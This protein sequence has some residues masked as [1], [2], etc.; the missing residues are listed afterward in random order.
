MS[1]AREE[2]LSRLSATTAV[3]IPAAEYAQL[4]AAPKPREFLFALQTD[5]DGV[6]RGQFDA[7][8]PGGCCFPLKRNVNILVYPIE[9]E[10]K[11]S[12]HVKGEANV[13]MEWNYIV[14]MRIRT[15]SRKNRIM[16]VV[17][18]D[19]FEFGG[20]EDPVI[21]D[22]NDPQVEK[23]RFDIRFIRQMVDV[24]PTFEFGNIELDFNDGFPNL[25]VHK[26]LLALHSSY[27]AHT[28]E[29]VENGSAINMG[30]TPRHCFQEVLYQIHRIQRPV[31]VDFRAL[32]LGALT[33]QV[34]TVLESLVRH[35]INYE[36]LSLEQKL[37]EAARLQLLDAIGELA[38]KAEQ[39]GTWSY[40]V[41]K[42]FDAAEELG[43]PIYH[44][45]ICPAI[46]KAKASKLGDPFK[47]SEFCNYDL[48]NPTEAQKKLSSPLIVHGTTL[49]INRGVLALLG[50]ERFG[51]GNDGELYPLVTGVLQDALNTSKVTLVNAL[52]ALFHYLYP[53]E[54]TINIE[55]VRPLIVFAHTHQMQKVKEELELMLADEPP[56]TPQILLDHLMYAENYGLE[57]LRRMCLLRVEGSCQPIAAKMVT[58]TEFQEILSARTRQQVLDRHCSGWALSW[59]KLW[60]KMPTKRLVRGVTNEVGGPRPC[61]LENALHTFRCGQSDMA[62]GGRSATIGAKL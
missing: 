43:E 29:D 13:P 48:K 3:S 31:W 15:G 12:I 41:G 59:T 45:V 32:T 42:G 11:H 4:V 25:R 56:F 6:V 49:W 50:T 20:R 1:T 33:Y 14:Q 10:G 58:L 36:R 2:E 44:M 7:R 54:K 46:V 23:L 62:F 27:M 19:V 5:E 52:E 9:N 38:Y 47:E 40:L 60:S 24:L 8:F 57:N 34:D 17:D 26:E 28:L 37:I 30:S 35:L 39:T 51:R 22:I 18:A 61:E 55:F 16:T 21:I 53:G